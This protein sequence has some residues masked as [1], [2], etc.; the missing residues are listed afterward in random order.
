M[1]KREVKMAGLLAEFLFESKIICLFQEPGK[2]A[3]CVCS[4]MNPRE[5]CM[6]T[7]F[8]LPLFLSSSLTL[9]KN[10]GLCEAAPRKF[11]K[12]NQ[13]GRAV[14]LSG[15]VANQNTGFGLFFPRAQAVCALWS[16]C[17]MVVKQ[18]VSH[19]HPVL[20]L[21]LHFIELQAPGEFRVARYGV[22]FG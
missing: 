15:W 7:L 10:Y 14:I 9:S 11:F 3:N 22:Q 20:P 5:S 4:T 12:H 13:S 18:S 16:C 19:L 21:A 8:W 2:K 6:F 1:T 17:I